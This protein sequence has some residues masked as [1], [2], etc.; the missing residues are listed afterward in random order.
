M[1]RSQRYK[2]TTLKSSQSVWINRTYVYKDKQQ[3]KI[4]Y[5]K[6]QGEWHRQCSS[7]DFIGEVI[8]A[9]TFTSWNYA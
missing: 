6:S 7:Q 1:V 5:T 2:T 8:T 9:D 3:Q 4:A